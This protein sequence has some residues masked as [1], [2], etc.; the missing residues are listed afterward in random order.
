MNAEFRFVDYRKEFDC[1]KKIVALVVLLCVVMVLST[2]SASNYFLTTN[3]QNLCMTFDDLFR[4][5]EREKA[6]KEAAERA[7][8]ERLRKEEARRNEF[9][10]LFFSIILT[11]GLVAMFFAY[12]YSQN[13]QFIKES[14]FM[15]W[16]SIFIDGKNFWIFI[17]CIVSFVMSIFYVP[18]NLVK[19]NNPAIVLKTAHA[20][21]F[22]MPKNFKSQITK[23]DYGA[24]TFREILILLGCCAGYT[25]STIIKKE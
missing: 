15:F 13:R 18:Y 22:E 24:I 14:S 4:E 2:V 6:E 1:L 16:L 12:K 8:Q 9:Y 10:Q 17:F 3:N 19:P 11:V 21:I 23:I 7:E 25:A 5:A 20:T